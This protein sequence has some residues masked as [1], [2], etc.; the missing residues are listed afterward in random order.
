MELNLDQ[1]LYFGRPQL[2]PGGFEERFRIGGD[3]DERVRG[4]RGVPPVRARQSLPAPRYEM[5]V[6]WVKIGGARRGSG[7]WPIALRTGSCRAVGRSPTGSVDM[8]GGGGRLR[9]Q[10][11]RETSLTLRLCEMR[12]NRP[13][14]A[15]LSRQLR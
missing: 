1:A 5:A 6:L 8:S 11:L 14:K 15:W 12:Y 4:V 13:E 2:G 9:P 10:A 7:Q 3:L